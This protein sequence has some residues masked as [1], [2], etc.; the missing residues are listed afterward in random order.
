MSN[1]LNCTLNLG[2]M[3][4]EDERVGRAKGGNDK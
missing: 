1:T 3:G 2:S 4:G